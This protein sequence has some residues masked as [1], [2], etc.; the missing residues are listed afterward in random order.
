MNEE[1]LVSEYLSQRDVACPGCRYNL[2]GIKGRVC[3][4]CGAALMLQ[5]V[6]LGHTWDD[7]DAE[8][9]RLAAFLRDNDVACP[10]C[11]MP[12][13]GCSGAQCPRC[14]LTLSLWVLKPRG[15]ERPSLLVRLLVLLIFLPVLAFAAWMVL[16]ALALGGWI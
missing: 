5:L 16:A 12:L 6:R 1:E 7:P 10:S 3:P 13:R 15:L 9:A 2:R 4:E 14:G 11:H 8:R